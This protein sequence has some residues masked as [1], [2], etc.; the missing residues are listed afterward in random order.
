MLRFEEVLTLRRVE[1]GRDWVVDVLKLR[2]R[3]NICPFWPLAV[4]KRPSIIVTLYI[5]H[6]SRVRR[7]S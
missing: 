4:E 6:L 7:I 1:D 2:Y 3:S 5:R